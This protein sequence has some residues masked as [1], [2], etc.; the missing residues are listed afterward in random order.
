VSL[1]GLIGGVGPESTIDYY[2]SI[3]SRYRARPSDGSY[4]P[5]IINSINL[6]RV[7]QLVEANELALLA[8]YLVSEFKRLVDAGAQTGAIAANMP[9]IVFNEV[10]QRISIPLVSIVEATRDAAA[11]SALRRLAILGTRF[12][13]TGRFYPDVFNNSGITLIVP[14]D[15]DLALV[16]DKYFNELVNGIFLPETREQIL[17]VI[18]RMRVSDEIDGV[19]LAG[20]ELPLLLRDHN[21]TGLPF[22]D[23]T[24][25]H[26]EA[27]VTA[28]LNE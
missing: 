1:F 19:I 13:M 14:N 26:V 22:L 6:Q 15:D 7:F 2:R 21:T 18:E 9:H 28:I 27:I 24:Q 16:H 17:A 11:Q 10:Q 25:I 3:V 8:D 12:T 20:T 4:P 5:L 23:T